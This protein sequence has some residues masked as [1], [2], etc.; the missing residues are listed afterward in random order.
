MRVT[1]RNPITCILLSLVTCGLYGLY[2]F[3]CVVNDLNAVSG[4]SHLGDGAKVLLLTIVT[5]GI[6]GWVWMYNAGSQVQKAQ[7]QRGLQADNKAV[8]FILLQICG[9]GIVNYYII[10]SELNQFA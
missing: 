7:M 10:Q 3:Y 4:D 1:F 9:L 8:I 2:W 5:C 6:Y